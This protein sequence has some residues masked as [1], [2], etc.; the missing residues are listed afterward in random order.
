MDCRSEVRDHA[1]GVRM[2]TGHLGQRSTIL[3]SFYF[4]EIS[5]NCK[6][7]SKVSGMKRDFADYAAYSARYFTDIITSSED[8]TDNI[9]QGANWWPS[10]YRR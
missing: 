8:A 6:K 10:A 4:F 1:L 7:L 9:P 5:H 2:L 3:I